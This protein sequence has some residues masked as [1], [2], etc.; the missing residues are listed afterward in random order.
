MPEDLIR[1]DT[2]HGQSN[3]AGDILLKIVPMQLNI[4]LVHLFS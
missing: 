3:V 2:N 1:S 4:R